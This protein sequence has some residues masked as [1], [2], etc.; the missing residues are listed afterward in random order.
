MMW[1]NANNG[2]NDSEN[3][4][5]K[6]VRELCRLLGIRIVDIEKD[7]IQVV[8]HPIPKKTLELFRNENHVRYYEEKKRKNKEKSD[9]FFEE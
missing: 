7:H 5:E 1:L 2:G 4:P 9:K 6:K 3:V 8:L